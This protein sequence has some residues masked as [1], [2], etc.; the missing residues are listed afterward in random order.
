MKGDWL[1]SEG[2]F[3]TI[4]TLAL[5]AI[6]LPSA[7]GASSELTF[8]EGEITSGGFYPSNDGPPIIVEENSPIAYI[9]TFSY[10]AGLGRATF[11]FTPLIDDVDA[12][13]VIRENLFPSV[14]EHDDEELH[15]DYV[16]TVNINSSLVNDFE[17]SLNKSSGQGRWRWY[18]SCPICDRIFDP[19]AEATITSFREAV[20]GDFEEDGDVDAADL[21]YWQNG[22]SAISFVEHRSGDANADAVVDGA[23]F[24]V[25]QRQL[26]LLPAAAVA[27]PEPCAAWLLTCVTSSALILRSSGLPAVRTSPS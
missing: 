18:E 11:Q 20:G 6:F 7:R 9:A 21:P 23:D 12:T 5:L 3:M 26:G 24:L 22:F 25:W 14:L 1:R 8:F 17:L 27:V 13:Q 10:D 19:A 4:R 16:P 15:I 2:V